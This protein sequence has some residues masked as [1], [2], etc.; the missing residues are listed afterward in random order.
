MSQQA[1]IKRYSLILEKIRSNHKPT[2][3]EIIT[4]IDDN[5]FEISKRTLQ[6]DIEQIRNEFGIE[7]IYNKQVNG[8]EIDEEHSLHVDSFLNFI[9]LVTT[10]GVLADSIREAKNSLQYISFDGSEKLQGVYHLSVLLKAIR[11]QRIISFSYM[12]FNDEE[13]KK[14]ELKPY[15]LK[16]YQNRWYLIGK[17]EKNDEYKT[18]GLDRITELKIKTEKFVRLK[19][20]KPQDLFGNIIGINYSSENKLEEVVLSFTPLQGKYIKTLPLHQSQKILIDTNKEL[21]ISLNVIPNFE[22][23]QKILT[24]AEYVKVI[25]PEWYRKEFSGIIIK[26]MK[27]YQ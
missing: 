27:K 7:I 24:Q 4:F 21:Q 10:A 16:S 1:T 20:E 2:F 9:D 11:L 6:R 25:S 19:N 22:L 14:H 5:G 3:D 12:K 26:M 18:F 23:S 8:Y 13:V 15:F 17:S